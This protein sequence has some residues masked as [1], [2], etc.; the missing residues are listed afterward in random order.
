[1][2]QK[3][4]Q[5]LLYLATER[6]LSVAY[7]LSVRQSLESLVDWMEKQ[8]FG[9]YGISHDAAAFELFSFSKRR[10]YG[11]KFFTYSYCSPENFL[12]PCH[13]QVMGGE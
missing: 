10:R 13:F 6:G 4:E 1:M 3:I 8:Y 7:Q 11:S 9:L 2:G 12:P 5:F